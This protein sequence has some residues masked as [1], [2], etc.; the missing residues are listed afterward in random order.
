MNKPVNS[1]NDPFS[2]LSNKK[3]QLSKDEYIKELETLC[4][5]QSEEITTSR[6]E[7]TKIEKNNL[8][9]LNTILEK[10]VEERTEQLEEANKFLLEEIELRLKTEEELKNAHSQFKDL[11][12][13]LPIAVSIIS[14]KDGS[15]RYANKI[16][17]EWLNTTLDKIQGKASANYWAKS[18]DKTRFAEMLNERGVIINFVS[19]FKRKP[20]GD[21]WVSVNGQ[22]AN[23]EGEDVYFLAAT[24]ID[25][26]KRSDERL[27]ESERK[28]RRLIE[29]SPSQI[30]ISDKKTGKFLFAN[31]S[32]LKL[33]MAS[34]EDVIGQPAELF[35]TD[36][37]GRSLFMEKLKE[38]KSVSNFELSIK[39]RT[40]ELISVLVGARITDFEGRQAI[41]ASLTDITEQKRTNESLVDEIAERK[42][43]E[44]RLKRTAKALQE[45]DA[46][47]DKF[48]SI[49]AHDLKNP[50]HTLIG[51]SDVLYQ[52][53][54]SL[55]KKEIFNIAE[56]LHE[57]A[58]RGYRLLENLLEWA[59][60][61]K[62]KMVVTKSELNSK[63][64]VKDIFKSL[65]IIA[66]NKEITLTNKIEN[67]V[68]VFADENML[69]TILRNLIS[70]AIKYTNQGGE[71]TV[72]GS[73]SKAGSTFE[74]CDNGVGMPE[75]MIQRLF[76][77]GQQVSTSGTANERGTGLGLILCKDML[78]K[79]RGS[80]KVASALNKGTTFSI[81][82]PREK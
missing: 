66:Q 56:N 45:A 39:K 69:R 60:L 51:F 37:S 8:L 19:K 12:L 3:N 73:E 42:L 80:I 76:Q 20:A 64:L 10:R 4:R 77:I 59:R 61:Q 71:I 44:K 13:N 30:L 7:I 68:T 32:V 22:L 57:A 47:K 52:D 33:L 34:A 15:V 58:E 79:Q 67:H 62:G 40:G 29:I 1:L 6:A 11:L 54:E 53:L 26:Q 82:L 75:Q 14:V 2:V 5:I 38:N 24:N 16:T 63:M 70:N 55:T 25:E 46:T 49:I 21:F 17:A 36:Q 28:F 74:V 78:E 41:M 50:F 9:E 23:F 18:A 48:F 72:T 27:L 65:E 43:V 35:Y 31:E 81:R